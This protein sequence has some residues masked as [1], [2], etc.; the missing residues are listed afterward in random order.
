MPV[1]RWSSLWADL[2]SGVRQLRAA[3]AVTAVLVG[4]LGLGLG[5][6]IAIFGVIHAVLLRPLPYAEADRLVAVFETLR[7]NKTGRASVG[8]FFDW[9][10]Q[11]TVF[12]ATA[13][14]RPA[15]FN[16]A[17]ASDVERVTGSQVTPGF[18]TVLHIAPSLGRYFTSDDVARNDHVVVLSHGLWLRRFGGDPRIIGQQVRLNDQPYTVVAVADPGYA[19]AGGPRST[20]GG[21]S[22]DLWTPL[23]FA[24]D[25]RTNYGNHAYLVIGKLNDRTTTPAAQADLERVTRGIAQ[26]NPQVMASRSV[27]VMPLE[28]MLV[29]NAR[30]QLYFLFGAV[31][32][33]LLIGCVNVTSVLLARAA[34]RRREIA[35]RAALGG[36]RLRIARQMVVESFVM[37]GVVGVVALIVGV[38]GIRLLVVLGPPGLARLS[39][40]RLS[41]AVLLFAVAA[42]LVIGS[43]VGLLPALRTA[44]TALHGRLAEG[45]QIGR[46]RSDRIRSTLVVVEVALTV[47]LLVAAGLLLHSAYAVEQVPLGF[48]PNHV[49]AGRVTLPPDRYRDPA[50]VASAFG[51][52]V[53]TLRA[54]G[55]LDATG[56][57][58][59]MPLASG[60]LDAVV[61]IEGQSYPRGSEPSAQIALVTDGYLEALNLPLRHGRLFA[62]ADMSAGSAPVV[63]VNERLASAIWPGED[64]IGKRLSTWTA[65][66]GTPEWREVVGVVGDTH[67][68]GLGA[69]VSMELFLPYRQAPIGAWDSFQRSM[70][71]VLRTGDPVSYVGALR[72]SVRAIDPT[73]AVFDIGTIAQAVSRDVQPRRLNTAL[74]SVMALMA[75]GLATLGLYGLMAFFVTERTPEIGLRMALGAT[76][77]AVLTIVLR[78]G[79]AL[80]TVGMAVGLAGAWGVSRVLTRLLFEVK[81]TDLSTYIAGACVLVLTA[82]IA[83]VVPAIRAS[84]IDPVRALTT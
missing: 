25:Q 51:R 7:E 22:P 28:D 45:R 37:A 69:P 82:L 68:F 41:P 55:G 77:G 38:F 56:A 1:E 2:R 63:I 8:H 6:T 81:P 72:R 71:I 3:P 57:S 11:G 83:I 50:A 61:T 54:G 10:E 5:F 62:A 53:E 46:D 32:A 47:V 49:L 44:A 52:M 76:A 58:T 33:V 26:R 66:V 12:T 16:L 59:T 13:A 42:T 74:L 14:L 70:N 17:A 73:L 48:D 19:I 20:A 29:G 30:T 18:F 23:T 9:T 80:T 34:G 40:S 35:I 65:R 24:A 78:R 36:G 60:H 27:N 39:Q 4:T 64:P 31:A 84:R 15:T 79:M 75:L 21:L 43:L 67:S